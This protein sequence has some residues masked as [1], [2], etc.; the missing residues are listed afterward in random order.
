MVCIYIQK[1]YVYGISVFCLVFYLALIQSIA[2]PLTE[3]RS[4]KDLG[5]LLYKKQVAEIALYGKYPTSAVF[6]SKAKI[7]YLVHKKDVAKY[8]P[9]S[10]S[11]SSKML[12]LILL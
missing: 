7:V 5:E 2:L 11:W 6:Y 10:Y 4:A 9:K 1:K 12:C 8:I 3:K